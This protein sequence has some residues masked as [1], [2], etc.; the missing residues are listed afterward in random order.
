[1]SKDTTR[2]SWRITTEQM[3]EALRFYNGKELKAEQT[4]LS[5]AATQ[6]EKIATGKLGSFLEYEER[7]IIRQAAVL[8]RQLNIR[9]EHAKETKV[10]EEKR[11]EKERKEFS[12]ACAKAI[13]ESFPEVSETDDLLSS[14]EHYVE[15]HLGLY[16]C[17]FLSMHL[18]S[19]VA[20]DVGKEI[21]QWS[22]E[23]PAWHQ[24]RR[25]VLG[26]ARTI[27]YHL[28]YDVEINLAYRSGE[29]PKVVLGEALEK[30]GALRTVIRA[31]N[32]ALFDKIDQFIAIEKSTNVERLQVK[33]AR[34]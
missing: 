7:E 27:L 14:I 18:T 11:L 8:V 33:K 1:M 16:K 10:R 25:S 21:A 3:L 32:Q 9:V 22:Q 6:L 13:A 24:V 34:S 28:K 29:I 26:S 23:Q 30:A 2:L 17:G 19:M 20:E 31:E 5:G 4:K 12:A 15:L